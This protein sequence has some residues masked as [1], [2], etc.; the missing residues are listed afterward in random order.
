MSAT[1]AS[2]LKYRMAIQARRNILIDILWPS[3]ESVYSK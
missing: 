3:L 2:I 1:G